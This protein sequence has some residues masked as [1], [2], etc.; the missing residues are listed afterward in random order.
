MGVRCADRERKR[1]NSPPLLTPLVPYSLRVEGGVGGGGGGWA[2]VGVFVEQ[3]RC[4]GVAEKGRRRGGVE[5][6]DP[7]V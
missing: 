1:R 6:E 5:N 2:L 7:G 4:K 3:G